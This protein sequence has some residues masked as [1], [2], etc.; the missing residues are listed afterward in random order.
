MSSACE[1]QL[2]SVK[3]DLEDLESLCEKITS[4]LQVLEKDIKEGLHVAR[5]ERPNEVKQIMQRLKNAVD[6]LESV[7]T[8]YTKYHAEGTGLYVAVVGE[9]AT[10]TVYARDQKDQCSVSAELVSSDGCSQVRGEVKKVTDGQYKVSYQPQH[11][12]PHY[13]HICVDEKHISGSPFPV[14]VLTTKPTKTITGLNE[15]CGLALNKYDQLVVVERKSHCVSIFKEDKTSFGSFGSDPGQLNN[16]SGVAISPITG[17]ILVCDKVNHRLQIFSPD[18]KFIKCVGDKKGSGP[19]QFNY[20]VSIAI[21]PQSKKVYIAERDNRR[22]QILKP[23]F[24]FCGFFDRSGSLDPYDISIDSNG[25]VYITD[26]IINHRVQVF[27]EYGEYIRE[28]GE[29]GN[30]EGELDQPRGIAIDSNDIIYIFEHTNHRISLFTQDGHYLKS[31][32]EQ[33]VGESQFGYP[34]RIVVSKNGVIYVSDTKG[35]FVIEF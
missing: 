21:H 29:K 14:S 27:T 34:N 2:A 19:L 11:R 22:V 7:S 24:T 10:V 35:G 15:P 31:I 1:K 3:E 30:E 25:D 16:P 9:E 17:D 6:R 5:H 8:Q 28:F 33:D 20:P 23:D 32:G 4:K 13:L 12:E 26:C 18:G